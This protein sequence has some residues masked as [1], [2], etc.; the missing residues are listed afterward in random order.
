MNQLMER[1][2]K[3]DETGSASV[4]VIRGEGGVLMQYVLTSETPGTADVVLV[5][6]GVGASYVL[7]VEDSLTVGAVAS[8][9]WT[10]F[11]PGDVN[12]YVSGATADTDYS[13]ALWIMDVD[14]QRHHITMPVGD[15]NVAEVK[16]ALPAGVLH[17]VGGTAVDEEGAD[18]GPNTADVHIVTDSGH[19][20][21]SSI[22]VAAEVS[23][24][25]NLEA[26]TDVFNYSPGGLSTVTVTTDGLAPGSMVHLY[27]DMGNQ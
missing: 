10:A 20:A 13:L 7:V 11:P 22:E 21:A 6:E 16:V 23:T 24:N 19:P 5:G 25:L 2:F 8:N 26:L 9:Q 18:V 4:H 27:L 14:V 12:L 17:S 1:H 3:T 15:A